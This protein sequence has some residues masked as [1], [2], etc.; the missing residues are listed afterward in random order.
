MGLPGSKGESGKK[1]LF[2]NFET[3]LLYRGFSYIGV[4]YSEVWTLNSML[5]IISTGQ[6]GSKGTKGDLGPRGLTGEVGKIGE[7]GSTGAKGS[8][9]PMGLPGSKGESG[10]KKAYV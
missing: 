2:K 10:K 1:K 8:M 4:L 3:T 9:G 7:V 6:N 5:F